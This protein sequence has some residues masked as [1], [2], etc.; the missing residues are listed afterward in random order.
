MNSSSVFVDIPLDTASW[1]RLTT[2][3][4]CSYFFISSRK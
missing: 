1:N 4:F 3:L 2:Q